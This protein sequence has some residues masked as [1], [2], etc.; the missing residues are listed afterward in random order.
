MI[1]SS[2]TMENRR[3]WNATGKDCQPRLYALQK[4]NSPSKIKEIKTFIDKQ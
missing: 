3:E 4:Q 2:D 1:F